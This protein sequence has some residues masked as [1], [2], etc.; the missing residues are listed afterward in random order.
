MVEFSTAERLLLG[1]YGGTLAH[2]L[3][4]LNSFSHAVCVLQDG[5]AIKARFITA[6]PAARCVIRADLAAA[7]VAES[8][9]DL[10]SLRIG[11][12]SDTAAYLAGGPAS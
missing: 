10:S 9:R 7:P 12:P 4:F 11:K 1:I 5:F 8:A 2:R 3:V 6:I